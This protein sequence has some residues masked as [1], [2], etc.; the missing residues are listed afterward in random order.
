MHFLISEAPTGSGKT[1]TAT[2]L[3]CDRVPRNVKT[4]IIQPTIR[5]CH[6]SRKNAATYVAQASPP[7]PT[8]KIKTIVSQLGRE[9]KVAHRITDYLNQ[10]DE[11]GDLLFLTHA[12]FLRTDYW[13]RARDWHLFVDEAPDIGYYRKF[14]LKD[15]HHELTS[16]FRAI[17]CGISE[18]Y[19]MLQARDH[20][21]L[22][23]VLDRLCDDEIHEAFADLTS[24]LVSANWSLY[25][26]RE[27][28]S[29]FER[30]ER[31]ELEVHGLLHPSIFEQFASVT[32][33]AAN[34][35]DTIMYRYYEKLGCTF[36][37]HRVI[38]DGLDYREH[39]NGWRLVIRYLCER[40]WSKTLRDLIV[41]NPDDEDDDPTSVGQLYLQLC[42][43]EAAK[44]SKHPPLWIANNDIGDDDFEGV[45]MTNVPHGMNNLQAHD[46]CCIMSALN[47]PQ[48]HR[49]FLQEMC[50]LTERDIRRAILS[51]TAYQACGRGILRNPNST[52]TF[53]LIVPD[54]DT[55]EDIARYYPGCQIEGLITDYQM[56]RGRG[57]PDKYD[58][59]AAREN[60]RR[61]QNRLH[62]QRVRNKSLNIELSAYAGQTPDEARASAVH[63]LNDW[64][65]IAPERN[66][67][68]A[69]A[70][71]EWANT[72]DKH[73][74][75]DTTF[76][77][78][79]DFIDELRRR[80][81][82]THRSKNANTLLSPTIF[83]HDVLPDNMIAA[84]VE[85]NVTARAK[86]NAVAC[87]GFVL[88]M[89]H[90]D[91]TPDD[92]AS[93]FPKIEFAA[94]SSWS[95]APTAPRY[96]IAI[97]STHYVPAA[98]HTL[99]LQTIRRRIEAAGWGNRH[100]GG[101]K[102]GIDTGKLQEA[103]MFYWPCHRPHAFL[104][105]QHEGREPLNP[106]E[107]VSLMPD[108]LLVTASP[109]ARAS[110]T[111]LAYVPS[112]DSKC[113][114]AQATDYWREHGCVKGA[115]RTQLWFLA[116]R[117][118]QSGCGDSQMRGI[119]WEQ[120]RYATNPKERRSEID[121]LIADTGMLAA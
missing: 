42:Q 57:R 81:A 4:A 89:E 23:L 84:G 11:T 7:T 37:E 101:P 19:N 85:L 12:G 97:P 116:K 79:P 75:G 115:G 117:L 80:Q 69:F 25:V 67:I 31:H 118:R 5:L 120:A 113:S 16:L 111:S 107:W 65:E 40:K 47:P 8:K 82:I 38:N 106:Y 24:R 6:Q 28:F 59:D 2:R 76:Q 102:H 33:M 77:P 108:E 13:H 46:V 103:A 105:H 14:R 90:G 63:I 26:E 104:V 112:G 95:H 114:V 52:G 73:G 34:L 51:Q 50:G 100:A 15:H 55:A 74:L 98:I 71:S 9:E 99:I 21:Q 22:Q 10:R 41:H 58:S 56:P 68:G 88:D 54:R 53:L 72:Q 86:D 60:A 29:A 49:V 92:F 39:Q 1:R 119:L 91:M 87:R 36:A 35:R 62:S 48:A 45:R 3:A 18:R 17:P 20:G 83:A 43:D 27:Q 94:Y 121:G 78:M 96:R 70:Y 64:A 93:L 109:Q 61:E 66:N 44:H 110:A 30:G 32:L